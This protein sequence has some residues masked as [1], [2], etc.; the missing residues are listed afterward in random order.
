M[1]PQT[2]TSA[3]QGANPTSRSST[4]FYHLTP[5]DLKCSSLPVSFFSKKSVKKKGN[6][7]ATSQTCSQTTFS[8]L[9]CAEDF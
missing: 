2:G 7:T 5:D 8:L 6:N 9:D 4:A 3:E 1:P